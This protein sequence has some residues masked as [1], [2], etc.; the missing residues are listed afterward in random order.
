[1]MGGIKNVKQAFNGL[2][3]MGNPQA[4]LSNAMANNPELKQ[5]MNECGGDYQKAFYKAAEI[6][7]VNPDDILSQLR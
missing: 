7:G 4:L 2:K 1:M 6:K 3:A 5:I